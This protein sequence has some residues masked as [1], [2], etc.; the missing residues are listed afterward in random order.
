MEEFPDQH[1]ERRF[2]LK[3]P[4][5]EGAF[6]SFHMAGD[7]LFAQDL[8]IYTF[9]LGLYRSLRIVEGRMSD[10][11]AGAKAI[12]KAAETLAKDAEY[13]IKCKDA[14]T[15]KGK[16]LKKG[17]N[18]KEKMC[19]VCE[20]KYAAGNGLHSVDNNSKIA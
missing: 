10:L 1:I 20:A 15:Y 12:R 11:A 7:K 3:L 8:A 13:A 17:C 4:K 18:G 5:T 6:Q 2:V 19:Q 9:A 16:R 14:D